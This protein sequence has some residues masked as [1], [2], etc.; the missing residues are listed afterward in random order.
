[1]THRRMMKHFWIICGIVAGTSCAA[2]EVSFVVSP[3]FL[4]AAEELTAS[5]EASS[6]TAV[7]LLLGDA[8][9]ISAEIASGGE[10]DLFALPALENSGAESDLF[11]RADVQI[12]ARDRLALVSQTTL[13]PDTL[14]AQIAGQTLALADPIGSPYGQ[15]AIRAMETLGLDTSTFQPMAMA[16]IDQVG[17]VFRNGEVSFAFASQADLQAEGANMMSL[18][19]GAGAEIAIFSGLLSDTGEARAFF[20]WL[21]SE[22][23][24][25]ILEQ[26]DFLPAKE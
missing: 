17:A 25:A 20:A 10:I 14:A 9:D 19:D 1:M 4:K 21:A 13:S 22:E 16:R 6:G 12:I 18:P 11:K 3:G 24:Q 15:L 5:F 26:V 23:A 8:E 7:S 2:Q